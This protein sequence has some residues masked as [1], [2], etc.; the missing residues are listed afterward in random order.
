MLPF[1]S[2]TRA[3]RGAETAHLG[4][5]GEVIFAAWK[6]QARLA[7]LA[8]LDLRTIQKIEAG[9]LTDRSVG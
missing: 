9:E 6:A 8:H 2:Y 5:V 3:L 7:E 4:G 1:R